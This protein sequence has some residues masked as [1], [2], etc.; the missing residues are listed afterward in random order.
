M[1]IRRLWAAFLLSFA[2]WTFVRRLD[3][4]GTAIICQCNLLSWTFFEIS[5]N[6]CPPLFF[7]FISCQA[8]FDLHFMFMC[9]LQCLRIIA[10]GLLLQE[11]Y[12][13]CID[14]AHCDKHLR[15]S[16]NVHFQHTAHLIKALTD[17]DVDYRTQVY[18][19][20]SLLH[21]RWLPVPRAC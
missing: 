2:P 10:G 12:N 4:H 6:S 7:H 16:D 18:R 15:F 17:A 11:A 1:I 3:E 13:E 21:T 9:L 5:P 20:F 8:F 14:A 19:T